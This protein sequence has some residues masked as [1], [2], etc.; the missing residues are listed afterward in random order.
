M[1]KAKRV[2]KEATPVKPVEETKQKID[3][4]KTGWSNA[5]LGSPQTISVK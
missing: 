4:K 3:M 5:L 2:K 1:A